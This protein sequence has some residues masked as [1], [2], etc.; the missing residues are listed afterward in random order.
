MVSLLFKCWQLPCISACLSMVY[1]SNDCTNDL[2]NCT[3]HF[4]IMRCLSIKGKPSDLYDQ[5][6]PDWAPSL[7][8]GGA[9]EPPSNLAQEGYERAALISEKRKKASEADSQVTCCY[10]L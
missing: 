7:H 3:L 5:N 1:H 10:E 2:H 4:V 8:L 6:N 9:P